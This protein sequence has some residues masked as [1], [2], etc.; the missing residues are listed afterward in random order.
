[1]LVAGQE[2]Q[3]EL[4]YKIEWVWPYT[5]CIGRKSTPVGAP[6]YEEWVIRLCGCQ[7]RQT[8]DKTFSWRISR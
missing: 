2:K 1:M 8:E 6:K 5:S 3:K 7:R 4:S